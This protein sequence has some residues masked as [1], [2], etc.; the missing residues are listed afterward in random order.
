MAL[1]TK[2]EASNL[3]TDATDATPSARIQANRLNA[4]RSTGPRSTEGKARSRRNSL[5]H[6]LTG[7]GVVLPP[8][9]EA[10]TALRIKAWTESL[11][12]RGPVELDLIKVAAT[13]MTR[14][15]LCWQE[16]SAAQR[17]AVARAEIAWDADR[18]DEA[19]QLMLQLPKQ[20]QRIVYA[21]GRTASGV[22]QMRES[23][24]ELSLRLDDTGEW[25]ESQLQMALDL[26]GVLTIF[27][28]SYNL[29][30]ISS[31]SLE[32][33]RELRRQIVEFEIHRLTEELQ[34][35]E[36]LDDLER[37]DRLKGLNTQNDPEVARLRRYELALT[38][39]VT[40]NLAVLR[41]GQAKQDGNLKSKGDEVHRVTATPTLPPPAS[42][43]PRSDETKPR[44]DLLPPRETKPTIEKRPV[45]ESP[46]P[47]QTNPIRPTPS[48]SS[49]TLTQPPRIV[50]PARTKPT[51]AQA[52]GLLTSLESI[53]NRSG[54]NYKE[55]DSLRSASRVDLRSNCGQVE[56]AA[57]L[58]R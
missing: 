11:A 8:D 1:L 36:D 38:R 14:V 43:A 15:E 58:A 12:P 39:R 19:A 47:I 18:L 52:R 16:E 21:L 17:R 30:D 51:E 37:D 28:D 20:P 27:R 10:Q 31:M 40:S 48:K 50:P 46:A 22:R 44:V 3:R 54:R 41:R 2:L 35:L 57:A 33:G 29:L 6:G 13:S 23:W 5:K 25:S 53:E 49:P 9:V 4:M 45:V 32:E 55:L 26:L 42:V 7:E 24:Q 34:W 56:I